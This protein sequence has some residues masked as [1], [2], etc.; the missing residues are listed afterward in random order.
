MAEKARQRKSDRPRRLRIYRARVQSELMK[1]LPEVEKARGFIQRVDQRRDAGELDDETA[2]VE[3]LPAQTV[4]GLATFLEILYDQASEIGNNFA[5]SRVNV[6]ADSL[7]IRLQ[8]G[9]LREREYP[10]DPEEREAAFLQ[11]L[12]SASIVYNEILEILDATP[13]VLGV[14]VPECPAV[15]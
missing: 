1:L 3:L 6:A 11:T 14:S 9:L 7:R 12:Q 13:E 15:L 10:D 2:A 5:L 4:V 8:R